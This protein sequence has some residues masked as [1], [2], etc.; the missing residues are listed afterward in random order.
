MMWTGEDPSV[1]ITVATVS[2]DVAKALGFSNIDLV[3]EFLN[4][5]FDWPKERKTRAKHKIET[6]VG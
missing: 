5:G 6:H 3:L 1:W 4:D 2:Y